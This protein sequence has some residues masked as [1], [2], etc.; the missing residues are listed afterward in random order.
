MTANNNTG[1]LLYT[2]WAV[3]TGCSYYI[4]HSQ[5]HFISYKAIPESSAHVKGLGGTLCMLINR[6]IVKL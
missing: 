1:N 3:N 6:E 5:K 4:T 2:Q